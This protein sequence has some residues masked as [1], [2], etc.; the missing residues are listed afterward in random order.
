M[1]NLYDYLNDCIIEGFYSNVNRLDFE[2][3]KPGVK[4]DYS[5]GK[6]KGTYDIHRHSPG[7]SYRISHQRTHPPT[8]QLPTGVYHMYL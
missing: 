6:F 7:D 4:I 2:W 8:S 5:Y 1:K 3:D